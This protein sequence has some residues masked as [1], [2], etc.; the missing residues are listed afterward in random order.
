MD[1]LDDF[2]FKVDN[3]FN[4]KIR[5]YCISLSIYENYK[6]NPISEEKMIHQSANNA[7]SNLA[8]HLTARSILNAFGSRL[9]PWL[10]FNCNQ[11]LFGNGNT[12]NLWFLE[13]LIKSRQ[14]LR[15]KSWSASKALCCWWIGTGYLLQPLLYWE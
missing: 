5:T 3:S 8:I 6:K 9:K 10:L 1:F 2:F 14:H 7:W 13:V 12:W 11:L 4:I 15:L